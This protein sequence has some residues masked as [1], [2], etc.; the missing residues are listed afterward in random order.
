MIVPERRLLLCKNFLDDCY[1]QFDGVD[2]PS[3]GNVVDSYIAPKNQ[4]AY[5]VMYFAKYVGCWSAVRELLGG[6]G[7]DAVYSIGCGPMFCLMG[8]YFDQPPSPGDKVIALDYLPWGHVRGF[9]SHEALLSD[10]L[11]PVEPQVASGLYFPRELPPQC[12]RVIVPTS[13]P[14]DPSRIVEGATVLFPM[15]LNH[16]VGSA[17]PMVDVESL[18]AWFRVLEQRAGRIIIVDMEN[19]K[20]PELWR[21]LEPLTGLRY[22]TEFGF[23]SYSGRLAPSYGDH[24]CPG[25][26]PESERRT[27]R[28]YPQFCVVTACIYES[29][30]GW[31]W[32]S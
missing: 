11:S 13:R 7:A 31:R 5:S 15:V 28:A 12:S 4:V 17:S 24:E 29:S 30:R 1:T 26:P 10:I 27:G 25:K 3:R 22:P 16:L 8:W 6:A 20:V 14:I 21:R 18:V 32:L 2:L 19:G 9:A 23:S